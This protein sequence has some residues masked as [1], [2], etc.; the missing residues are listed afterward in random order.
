[1]STERPLSDKL[2]PAIETFYA[3]KESER[4]A[5][6]TLETYRRAVGMFET[7]L[8][9]RG[10]TQPE[11]ITPAHVRQYFAELGKWG[12]SSS[13]IHDYARPVKTFL[14][15]KFGQQLTLAH[16]THHFSRSPRP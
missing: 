1:M 13:S 14:R 2:A 4:I 11:R 8:R 10:I 5:E 16:S 3:A 12:C 9:E 7:W 6:R 15:T